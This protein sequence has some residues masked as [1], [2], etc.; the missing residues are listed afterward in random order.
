[1]LYTNYWAAWNPPQGCFG[2]IFLGCGGQTYASWGS[3][4]E[5]SVGH[6]SRRW[7]CGCLHARPV[8]GVSG[9]TGDG[10][11]GR[12]FH[13]QNSEAV[14]QN[15]TS[16]HSGFFYHNS[17]FF[18]VVIQISKKP[19]FAEIPL[20]LVKS[21]H[22]FTNTLMTAQMLLHAKTKFVMIS[23][24]MGW[25]L[26]KTMPSNL[27][28]DE[29]SW[30]G[31][32]AYNHWWCCDEKRTTHGTMATKQLYTQLLWRLRLSD[33]LIIVPRISPQPFG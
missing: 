15:T 7:N 8:H 12:K 1:M 26:N 23:I 5:R 16:F 11:G 13:R 10:R 21:R 14:K 32:N 31:S 33:S 22:I 6:K 17:P 19:T 24:Q 20:L 30:N 25:E 29:F 4:S 27:N 28:Y 18:W 9:G 3:V 2:Q